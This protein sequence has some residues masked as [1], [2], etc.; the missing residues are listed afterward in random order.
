[1]FVIILLKNKF[2]LN[3][4]CIVSLSVD[5][6]VFLYNTVLVSALYNI[7]FVSHQCKRHQVLICMVSHQC[8]RS[9]VFTRFLTSVNAVMCLHGFSPV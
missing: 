3:C 8:E 1:M 2:N 6:T 7:T 4:H 9:R 5:F